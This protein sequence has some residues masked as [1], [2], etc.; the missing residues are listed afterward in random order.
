MKHKM[1]LDCDPGHDDAIAILLAAHH[2]EI[3]LLAIT[4]VAGN[5]SV[6]KTTRNAL[7]VC[8]LANIRDIPI[9]M[10]MDRPLVRRAKHALDIKGESV[11]EAPNIQEPTIELTRRHAVDLLIDLLMNSDGDITLVPTG[12][13]TNIAAAI[14]QQPAIVPKIKAISLMGGAIGLGNV[15][16]AAEFNIHS[17]PEAAA[18]V[19]GC[20]RPITMVPLE[21]TH[22]ALAT[23]DVTTRL[24]AVQRPV[25]NFTADLLVFSADTY[26]TVLGFPAAPVHDPCAVAAVVDPTILRAHI[27][28]LKLHPKR[29]ASLLQV[30][31][32]LYQA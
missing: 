11:M 32:Q 16:P 3:E 23:E 26:R 6:E 19:F 5:Q 17:D 18:I 12:P 13:L 27:R 15:T 10:G 14:R 22:Q 7:K 25:A 9:A 30:S 4:T 21:V 31:R 1:I 20:G 28:S 2:P 24:R 8:S 29:Y